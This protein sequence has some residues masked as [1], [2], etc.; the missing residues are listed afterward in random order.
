MYSQK[1][2][3]ENLSKL[4]PSVKYIN[5]NG[6]EEEVFFDLQEHSI[7]ECQEA[8]EFFNSKID[9]DLY[10]K[11]VDK[12]AGKTKIEFKKGWKPELEHL[13]WIENEKILCKL[14][15]DYWSTRYYVVSDINNRFV[16]YKPNHAQNIWD[17]IDARMEE[18]GIAVK[19]QNG[20]ARQQGSTTHSQGKVQHRIQFYSDVKAITASFE[21]GPTQIMAQ[22]ITDSMARQPFWLRPR[23]ENMQTDN[24]YYYENKSILNLGTGTAKVLSTGTTPTVAHLSE[25]PKFLYPEQAITQSLLPSMHEGI[26]IF[27][28]LEGTAEGRNN[29]WHELWKENVNGLEDGTYLLY[30]NF[31]PYCSREDIYPTKEWILQRSIAFERWT[32]KTETIIHA[33][34]L[35]NYFNTNPDLR[36][37]FGAN[38]RLSREKMFWYETERERHKKNGTLHIFLQ[39]FPADPEEMFQNPGSGIYSIEIVNH[40]EL[41]AGQ[42]IPEVYK[43]RGDSSEISPVLLP[44]DDEIDYNKPS[45]SILPRWD[46]AHPNSSYELVPIKFDGWERFKPKNK[47]LIFEK[48]SIEYEY[49]GG[50]DTSDGLGELLSNDACVEILRKGTVE[51]NDAQVCEFTSPDLPQLQFWPVIYAIATYY[52]VVEQIL[53]TIEINK[54]EEAQN[55]I[56]NRG[57]WNLFLRRDSTIISNN[58]GETRRFGLYTSP[59]T[60]DSL[61]GHLHSFIIGKWLDIYSMPLIQE[62][63][64]LKKRKLVTKDK[65]EG[66]SDN[67]FVTTGMALYGLNKD[68]FLGRETARWEARNRQQQNKII[69]PSYNDYNKLN[70]VSENDIISPYNDTLESN[71]ESIYGEDLSLEDF[72]EII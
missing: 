10:E 11:T 61:L 20:K 49:G 12:G 32:P 69:L 56:K 26:R 23:I 66:S 65:I 34:K 63:K 25:I 40:H 1:I 5:K 8:V 45:I 46:S 14:S 15:W 71:F 4:R 17:R 3:S 18:K 21:K 6:R 51:D 52:S 70:Q 53:L 37:E 35:K 19:R 24:Y 36:A 59:R 33:N 30:P 54:G 44:S 58:P 2:V 47:I 42:K 68:Q 28:V 16:L 72:E 60:R 39:E 55:A 7:S 29:Y 27:L 38:W 50:V 31:I 67:R 48:P 41:N 62:M 22:M 9:F 13:R 57:W 43:I 64:D